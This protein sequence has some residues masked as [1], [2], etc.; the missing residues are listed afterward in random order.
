MGRAVEPLRQGTDVLMLTPSH[1]HLW[2]FVSYAFL[3]ASFAH[4]FGNMFFLFLFGNNVNGKLGNIGYI[5]FYLAGAIF[6]AIGHIMVGGGDVLGASGA[7]AAVTGAYLVLFPQTLITI[8][9]WFIII[10]TMEV[11]ALYFIAFKMIFIDNVLARYTPNVAYDAHLSGYA[12]G[13]LAMLLL[14]STHLLASDGI[15]LGVMLKQWRRRRKYRDI[16]S[17]EY[18]PF[19]GTTRKKIIVKEVKNPHQVELEQKVQQLR[20]EIGSRLVQQNIPVAA[21]L[22]L[23]LMEIDSKQVLPKQNLLDIANQLSSEKNHNYAAMAYE[24]F[25]ENYGNYEYSEQV[26]LM[27]GIIYSRYLGNRELAIRY[28][29]QAML[30]LTDT[31][32]LEMCKQ[33]LSK[34]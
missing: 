27:L 31:G 17:Q 33:E 34:L 21:R 1:L 10:G 13:M 15:D 9:Y 5:C 18:D 3:H 22:Y 7:V 2:Q 32:Q 28:L 23:E 24:Q 25:L 12:F 20:S 29:N 8:I 14:L 30:K 26:Q 11:S 4:I 19:T 16:V 6:S